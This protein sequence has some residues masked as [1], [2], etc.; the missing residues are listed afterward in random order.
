MLGLLQICSIPSLSFEG[1]SMEE[2]DRFSIT[3]IKAGNPDAPSDEF[4]VE[5]YP[6]GKVKK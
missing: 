2:K 3:G 4:R 5:F 1:T 6:D